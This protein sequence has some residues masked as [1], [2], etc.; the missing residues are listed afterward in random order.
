MGLSS[1]L[2]ATLRTDLLQDLSSPLPSNLLPHNLHHF[3]TMLAQN[4]MD[5]S[6]DDTSSPAQS[7]LPSLEVSL[8]VR[9]VATALV[10]AKESPVLRQGGSFNVDVHEAEK[11][12][13][14]DREETPI[15]ERGGGRV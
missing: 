5:L 11:T 13:G 12:L 14:L 8:A 9:A 2:R 7:R 3:F 4:S 1:A 10:L 6:L 15:A